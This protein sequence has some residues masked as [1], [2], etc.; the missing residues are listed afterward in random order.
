MQLLIGAFA[1]LV[2]PVTQQQA[3]AQTGSHARPSW[4]GYYTLASG[5]QLA[6]TGFKQDY[7]GERLSDLIIPHLQP[8][9]KARRWRRPSAMRTPKLGNNS[10]M[11]L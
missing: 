10:G 7:P 9:A 3:L 1:L 4:N 5:R 2:I 11:K 8:W 6:D